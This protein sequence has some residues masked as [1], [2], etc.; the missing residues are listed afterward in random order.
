MHDFP[1]FCRHFSLLDLKKERR[2]FKM[3]KEGMGERQKTF[4]GSNL[5]QTTF[6][7]K[8]VVHQ[9]IRSLRP[10]HLKV[11]FSVIFCQVTLWSPPDGKG[12]KVHR[13]WAGGSTWLSGHQVILSPDSARHWCRLQS[14]NHQKRVL[15]T[16]TSAKASPPSAAQKELCRRT[17][18]VEES[19]ILW[20]ASWKHEHQDTKTVLF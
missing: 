11:S 12:T 3:Q 8:Q 13:S 19:F 10:Q 6:K 7:L 2:S 1:I 17:K 20:W 16:K 4:W 18:K 9:L 14:H 5:L 15:R